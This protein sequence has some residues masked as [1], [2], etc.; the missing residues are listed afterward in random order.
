MWRGGCLCRRALGE[1]NQLTATAHGR[2]RHPNGSRAGRPTPAGVQRIGSD[3]RKGPG[4]R[5]PQ[6]GGC[7]A[8]TRTV[9]PPPF[10]LK[11]SLSGRASVTPAVTG[12]SHQPDKRR[13]MGRAARRGACLTN[14]AARHIVTLSQPAQ[15]KPA[16]LIEMTVRQEMPGELRVRHGFLSCSKASMRSASVVK[17]VAICRIATAPP[18][19]FALPGVP[20]AVPP[21]RSRLEAGRRG[22]YARHPGQVR[23]LPPLTASNSRRR[24]DPDPRRVSNRDSDGVRGR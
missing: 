7:K 10:E 16:T 2:W 15:S 9:L 4:D 8:A 11:R 18:S 22:T 6:R 12:P 3:N 20:K 24:H 19:E 13:R 1:G 17:V 23:R 14:P 21:T 5:R